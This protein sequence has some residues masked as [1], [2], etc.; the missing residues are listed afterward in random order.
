MGVAGKNLRGHGRPTHATP[1]VQLK[2][3][4]YGRPPHPVYVR[5]G[6]IYWPR[7]ARTPRRQFRVSR[8]YPGGRVRAR[9][10]DGA[11][12]TLELTAERLLAASEDGVGEDYSFIGWMPGIY[13][14]W[15]C[16]VER[17]RERGQAILILPEWH[18]CWPVRI[19]ERLL[20]I[21]VQPPGGWMRAVADFSAPNPAR[22]CLG[23]SG[24]C[25]DPGRGVCG[26]PRWP[27][28]KAVGQ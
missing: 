16:A 6:Q 28:A 2:D 9:R 5:T 26:A 15:A 19:P 20:A 23:L 24:A 18:P 11:G 17:D 14:T 25:D 13:G 3:G 27:P 4:P 21:G 8:V 7:H 10:M 22:L 1:P 12:E